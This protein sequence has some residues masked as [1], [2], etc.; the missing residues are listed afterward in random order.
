M[1]TVAAE[2]SRVFAGGVRALEDVISGGVLVVPFNSPL[3]HSRQNVPTWEKNNDFLL[4]NAWLV[5]AERIPPE[6]LFHSM[7]CLIS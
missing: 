7:V 3:N 6:S 5:R 2:K 4:E 1:L